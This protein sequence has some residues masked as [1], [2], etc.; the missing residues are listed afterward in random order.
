M[1]PPDLA[2][3]QLDLV[4]VALGAYEVARQVGPSSWLGRG[5]SGELVTI[6]VERTVPTDALEH[7]LQQLRHLNHPHIV[8]V[9]AVGFCEEAGVAYLVREPGGTSLADRDAIPL[10]AESVA[11]VA[12]QVLRALSSAHRCD[13]S[14]GAISAESVLIDATGNAV[15]VGFALRE[16]EAPFELRRQAD[17]RAAAELLAVLL[18]KPRR[19]FM[20]RASRPDRLSLALRSIAVSSREPNWRWRE[21]EDL[22]GA[23]EGFRRRL[24]GASRLSNE[25]RAARWRA[26]SAAVLMTLSFIAGAG[27]MRL[28]GLDAREQNTQEEA[29]RASP[30]LTTAGQRT[31]S[32]TKPHAAAPST[33]TISPSSSSS[34]VPGHRGSGPSGTDRREPAPPAVQAADS[35]LEDPE[36][37]AVASNRPVRSARGDISEAGSSRRTSAVLSSAPADAAQLLVRRAEGGAVDGGTLPGASTAPRGET[38]STPTSLRAPAKLAWSYLHRPAWGHLTLR[39]DG[40]VAWSSPLPRGTAGKQAPPTIPVNG[41]LEIEPGR[42]EIEARLVLTGR[43]RREIVRSVTGDFVSGEVA[44][45]RLELGERKRRL[46]ANLDPGVAPIDAARI[47]GRP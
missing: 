30:V 28:V 1:T 32:T 25:E 36:A 43:Q 4:G 17:V 20:R 27:I 14:H 24:S 38:R 21:A 40:R 11:D 7:R 19:R 8:P 39:V 12:C 18:E 26:V 35:S 45:L 33:P 47:A 13:V 41:T 42:H 9:V 6:E 5:A 16:A 23:I 15:L 29:V 44:T 34:Q 3:S 2:S 22:G 37:P 46:A 31:A 10:D